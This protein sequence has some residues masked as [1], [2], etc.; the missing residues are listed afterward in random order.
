M[1]AK[2]TPAFVKD[3]TAV[4][5]AERTI[6]WDATMP[7][8]GLMVTAQGA[9]S[10]VVQYRASRRSRRMKIDSV[11]GLSGARKRAKALLGEV[12]HGRD[13]LGE[14]RKAEAL[15]TN[16]LKSVAESYLSR[17]GKNL[18]SLKNRKS[19]F[20]R[21]IFPKFGSTPIDSI[22]RSDITNLLDKV[23][24][25]CGPTAA[26]ETL[27]ILRRV[28]SWHASRSDDFR[29]P[30]VRGMARTNPAE[31]ARKRVLNDK[32]LR[33]V[34]K[35]ATT[36]EGP[37]GTLVRFLLLTAARRDEARCMPRS[38][39]AGAVWTI[40]EDRY[41]TK[42]EMV[43]PLSKA[44]QAI[45]AKLPDLGPFLF[46]LNG[47]NPIGGLTEHK[48]NLDKL[49]GV[50]GWRIHDTRRTA[51]SL[52]SRAGVDADIAERCL[53]HVIGGVRGVYDQHKYIEEMRLAFEKL[54]ALIE[55]IVNP[56][57]NVVLLCEGLEERA[58]EAVR[59]STIPAQISGPLGQ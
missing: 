44:A 15:A 56:Q 54:A 5:G 46:S 2:L 48:T 12:A 43:L 16:T 11:L 14:K 49:S 55:S 28:F 57:E 39:L 41:K 51:R 4:P 6:F 52:M 7:G 17:E 10:Y 21:N 25:E 37:Y 36:T 29:S 47:R 33:A 58:K 3:A 32:E 59:H 9:K 23:A 53:G 18:R 45:L 50:T 22:R 24:D 13:P 38:E 35:A 19:I 34:W 30:I 40:P 26:D 1:K 20:K 8:F 31:R 42:A 27:A